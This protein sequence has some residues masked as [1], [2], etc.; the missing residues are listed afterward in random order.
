M[1]I[2]QRDNNAQAIE[3]LNQLLATSNASDEQKFWIEREIKNIKKGETGEKNSAYYLDFYFGESS[4]NWA[5]IHDLRLEVDGRVAQIDHLLINRFFEIYVLESKNFYNGVQ[6]N[7]Q[8]E[9]SAFYQ[10]KTYGIPS[11]IEQNERHIAV[12]NDLLNKADLLPRRMGLTI[13]LTFISYILIS[14]DSLIKRPN[15]KTF[16]TD[17]VIKADALRKVL[18]DKNKNWTPKLS[19]VAAMAK[20]VSSETIEDFAYELSSFHRPLQVDWQKKFKVQ[21]A[22][23]SEVKQQPEKRE[24]T[25]NATNYFCAKYKVNITAKVANFCWNNKAKFAGRA[26]C[27]NCQKTIKS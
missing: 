19:D 15:K 26:Y 23:E 24:N 12:L 14:P 8:G 22:K 13:K 2:K 16:D 17:N 10:K 7:E 25:Q 27:F 4:Q 11:P 20:I 6:I 21:Q 1:I 5:V 3:T 9:F 18:D